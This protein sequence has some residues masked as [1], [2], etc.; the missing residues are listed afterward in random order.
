MPQI[1]PAYAPTGALLTKQEIPEGDFMSFFYGCCVSKKGAKPRFEAT[2]LSSQQGLI[3]IANIFVSLGLHVAALACSMRVGV[4]H[5]F[6]LREGGDLFDLNNKKV[7]QQL[8]YIIMLVPSLAV[9][10]TVVI[11]LP[12]RHSMG[13]TLWSTALGGSFFLVQSAL[14]ILV[15]MYSLGLPADRNAKYDDTLMAA[16]ILST[17][18]VAN[19]VFQPI[20]GIYYAAIP[21]DDKKEMDKKEPIVNM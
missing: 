4:T 13:S 5:H 3:G 19:Y 10:L 20:C 2:P 15:V 6:A 9:F 7:F 12:F 21:E 16:W 8:V 17:F 11:Y 14:T 18:V 1:K